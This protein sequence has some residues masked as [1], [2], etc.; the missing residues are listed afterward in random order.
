[1]Q[2]RVLEPGD[3]EWADIIASSPH[4][5]YHL[6]AY[7]SLCAAHEGGD[8]VAVVVRDGPHVLLVPLVLRR[9]PGDALMDAASPYGYGGPIGT[10][11]ASPQFRREAFGEAMRLLDAR[12]VVACFIRLHPL[13]DPDPTPRVGA[14]VQHGETVSVDL[15]R[16]SEDMWRETRADH[17]TQIRQSLRAGTAARF[18]ATWDRLSSFVRLYRRTMDRVSASRSYYF[19]DEYFV[20]LRAALGERLNL[21]VVE[22]GGD[23]V[24]AALFVEEAGIVQYHLSG[25]DERFNRLRPNKVML[26]GAR[27][28]AKAR[29]N[30]VLHLGGGVG[31]MHDSLFEFKAGFSPQRH[32]F[33]TLRIVIRA[34]DYQ[35]LAA[36]RGRSV[37]SGDH[38]GY[39]PSYR[40]ASEGPAPAGQPP[41]ESV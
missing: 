3:P 35:R 19:D 16:S 39:F 7:A 22:I 26:H 41:L 8:A 34:R 38:L 13:L 5:F 24:A 15:T 12:G 27:E 17:R 32:P 1:M 21:G 31:G 40:A 2:G 6:P 11:D 20:R 23:V 29:G 28:W 37:D 14:V 33:H 36:Q 18:D 10:R 25:S 4:D 30:R 9:I